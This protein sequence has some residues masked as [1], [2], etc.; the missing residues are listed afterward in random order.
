MY[1]KTTMTMA[2]NG[3]TLT[4]RTQSQKLGTACTPPTLPG[5]K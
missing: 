1:A 2:M 4:M 3:Q 5:A